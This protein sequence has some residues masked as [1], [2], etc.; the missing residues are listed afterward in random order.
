MASNLLAMASNL[1]VMAS[2]LEAFFLSFP[3]FSIFPPFVFYFSFN[4][5]LE[6]DPILSHPNVGVPDCHTSNEKEQNWKSKGSVAC[7]ALPTE[8]GEIADRG[9]IGFFLQIL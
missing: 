5:R 4:S 8:S 1:I 9:G 6:V 2:N 3:S 7:L